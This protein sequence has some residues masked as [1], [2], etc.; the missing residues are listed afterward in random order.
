[1]FKALICLWI[2][3]GADGEPGPRGQQGMNG[4]KGDEGQ[5]GFKGATGPSGLQVKSTT[6]SKSPVP[7]LWY[8]AC[9]IWFISDSIACLR[10]FW[11]PSLHLQGM[12]GP[13][14]EKGES[15][16]VGSMV[17]T[18]QQL[19]HIQHS[20]QVHCYS[21]VSV[22]SLFSALLFRHLAL[23]LMIMILSL[24]RLILDID[25][26]FSDSPHT[27]EY[28]SPLFTLALIFSSLSKAV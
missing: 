8:S 4:A 10:Q 19:Q 18:A 13:P 21:P 24:S 7:H 17:S 12:P 2:F 20:S 15:G 23:C 16:H 27:F 26:S 6:H 9:I 11:S 25:L 1:M 22:S 14:G 3:Q 28:I 5:R